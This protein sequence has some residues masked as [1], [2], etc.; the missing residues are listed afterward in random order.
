MKRIT[1]ISVWGLCIIGLLS[2]LGYAS[3]PEEA[4]KSAN[5]KPEVFLKTGTRADA[6][7]WIKDAMLSRRFIMRSDT[8]NILVFYMSILYQEQ[9]FSNQQVSAEYRATFYIL[10]TAEGVRVVASMA[11]IKDPKTPNEQLLQ[12]WSKDK[13]EIRTFQAI[14]NDMKYD[15]EDPNPGTIG[16][17]T[18]IPN[19]NKILK[20][21]DD[22]QAKK[23]GLKVGETIR[24][25]DGKPLGPDPVENCALLNQEA[26]TSHE[27]L[28]G[29]KKNPRA[30]T[31]VYDKKVVPGRS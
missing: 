22:S 4:I 30:I 17:I 24:A 14:L 23:A 18:E 25:I 12:D 8:N 28:V 1:R 20:I 2:I 15:F 29:K 10:N 21:C 5:G 27:L 3:G 6:I 9:M 31:I 11:G 7:A 19:G 13:K 16:I 26:G